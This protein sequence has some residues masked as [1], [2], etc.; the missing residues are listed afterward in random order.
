MTTFDT[1]EKAFEDK[2]AHDLQQRFEATARR[3]RLVGRW[4]AAK[5]GLGTVE[6]DAYVTAICQLQLLN[7]KSEQV[8]LKLKSD[9][10]S[11]NVQMS[12]ADLIKTMSDYLHQAMYEPADVRRSH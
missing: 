2:Y 9:F 1:R 7:D 10:T 12:D 6:A 8:F 3:N 11:N 4:A 5:L